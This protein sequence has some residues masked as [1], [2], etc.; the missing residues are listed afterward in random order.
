MSRV[1]NII[2]ACGLCEE[3]GEGNYPPVNAINEWLL[4]NGQHVGLKY[5]NGREGGHKVWESEVF[6]GAF[7]FLD[8][9]AF[10]RV[11]ASAK[12]ERADF[13]QVFINGHEEEVFGVVN[14][15]DASQSRL[16]SNETLKAQEALDQCLK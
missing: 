13:V 12:W 9:E 6:G 3:N 4:E 5:I 10:I 16:L 2:L 15:V 11:V 1:T 14:I 8:I 7:N